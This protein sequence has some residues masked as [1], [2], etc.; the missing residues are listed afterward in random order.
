MRVLSVLAAALLFAGCD[1]LF[2]MK[3]DVADAAGHPIAGAR[4][5]LTCGG[6]DQGRWTDTDTTGHFEDGRVGVFG[7]DCAVEIRATGHSPVVFPVMANC[8]KVSP[9]GNHMCAE[10]TVHATIP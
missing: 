6:V 4:A 2:T 9:H 7:K 10:V 8:T 1:P 3:G 5:A